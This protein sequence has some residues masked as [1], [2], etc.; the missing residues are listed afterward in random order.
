M[1]AAATDTTVFPLFSALAAELRNQIWQ[2]ALPKNMKEPTLGLFKAGSWRI[3]G[4]EPDL[5]LGFCCDSLNV[6]V[7]MPLAFVDHEARS[8][9][10]AKIRE[11]GLAIRARRNQYP[12]LVRP[13]KPTVDALYVSLSALTN[14]LV[15]LV[16]RTF[17]PDLIER[18]VEFRLPIEKSAMTQ[19]S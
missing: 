5:L 17:E 8:I 11:H 12:I 1:A 6:D 15:D 14:I 4:A 7:E 2:E 16:D 10:L 18:L 13:F 3:Q 19:E 9:A